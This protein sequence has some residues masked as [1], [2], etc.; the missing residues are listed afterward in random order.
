MILNN[1]VFPGSDG[2]DQPPSQLWD[3]ELVDGIIKSIELAEQTSG[4]CGV[5]EPSADAIASQ[6]FLPTLC[7]PHLH[8]DK[9]YLLTG[10]CGEAGDEF[11][12]YADLLP[13]TGSFPEALQ[14]TAVAKSRFT[15]ADLRR[16]GMQLLASSYAQGVTSAR[17]FVE[18]DAQ[19]AGRGKTAVAVVAELQAL[20][21][22]TL[23]LQVCAFAQ[24]VLFTGDAGTAN[25]AAI[26]EVLRENTGSRAGSHKDR[27]IDV[28]GVTPYVEAARALSLQTIDW[29][30]ATALE[31]DLHLDLHLDYNLEACDESEPLIFAL[32]EALVRHKWTERT[33]QTQAETRAHRTVAVGHA[34]QL[35]RLPPDELRRLATLIQANH[36]P[37]HLVG[38]PTSD[39]YMMGRQPDAAV[40]SSAAA[41]SPPRGTLNV[42]SLA[43]DYGL[44]TCLG[45][46]NVGNA[47]TPYGT[48]DPLQLACWGVGLYHAGGAGDAEALY[49]KISWAARAAI[50]LARD[51]DAGSG[52][53]G[54]AAYEQ[55]LAVGTNVGRA[56]VVAN[57]RWV[58]LPPALAE[59]RTKTPPTPARP[60]RGF[61]DVVWD[62]PDGI[63]MVEGQV[64]IRVSQM[65]R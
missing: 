22:N 15:A 3:I 47:F 2:P 25:R 49:G 61:R 14:T 52:D 58:T 27:V 10:C 29:A 36:L 65:I 20:W 16:R 7:H 38:L 60:R 21:K 44:R 17:V 34:T 62:P 4:S 30:V 35:T 63:L 26:E 51:R 59:A 46:N 23:D 11:P 31:H 48:G 50:G 40:S 5:G 39:L 24:E 9:A 54:G 64:R 19:A 18:V 45:I 8:L 56:L 43:R 6:L 55:S 12:S 1:V 33:E 57:P 41:T 42:V 13:Q 53:T 32:V 28:L 37:I